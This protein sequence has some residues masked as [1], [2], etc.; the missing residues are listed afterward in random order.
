MASEE[1]TKFATNSYT[2]TTHYVKERKHLPANT[3]A[4]FFSVLISMN[5]SRKNKL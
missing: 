5:D 4:S 2:E 3:A 1:S